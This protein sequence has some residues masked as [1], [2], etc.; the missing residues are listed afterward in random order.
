MSLYAN[1]SG[2]WRSQGNAWTRVSSVWRRCTVWVNVSGT[3]KAVLGRVTVSGETTSA[4]AQSGVRF[5]TDG[6]VDIN[7]QGI[8][9]QI[10]SATDWI[11]PNGV[12]GKGD[13]EVRAVQN[14]GDAL[15]GGSDALNTW[16]ALSTARE[17]FGLGGSP[18]F[19]A[20]LTIDIRLAGL[21][22]GSGTYIL[23]ATL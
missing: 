13:Y 3:W 11:I 15:D 10:D 8:Y 9:S 17:W 21:T 1:V 5:N 16:L 14:S 23:Q 20:N 7:E 4:V 2:T 12:D 18:E 19:D 22:L 6:T